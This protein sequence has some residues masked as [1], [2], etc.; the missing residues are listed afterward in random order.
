MSL[1]YSK[2]N[3]GCGLLF[4]QFTWYDTV[5]M[6][7]QAFTIWLKT[8]FHAGNEGDVEGHVSCKALITSLLSVFMLFSLLRTLLTSV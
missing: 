1:V 7:C 8:H 2:N 3:V 6:E 5:R 4:I